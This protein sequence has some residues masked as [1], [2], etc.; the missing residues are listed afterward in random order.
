MRTFMFGAVLAGA[1]S[2]AALIAT[3]TA[4]AA[5]PLVQPEQG[6]IGV[7]LSHG[8]TAALADGPLPALIS[9]VVPLS[10]MGAGLRPDTRIYRDE[11]GGVHASLRE[12]LLESADHP[13]GH[14]LVY[15]DAPGTHGTRVL[16][17]YERWG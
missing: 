16:D 14:V 15:L 7:D 1:L 10:R 5:L 12:L 4:S 6:R 9:K 17:I 13:G 11:H 8:E 3:A 2:G